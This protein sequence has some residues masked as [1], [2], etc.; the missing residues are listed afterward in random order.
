MAAHER[1]ENSYPELFPQDLGDRLERFTELAGLLGVELD[2]VMEWRGGEVPIGGEVWHI[3]R[4]ALSVSG[5]MDV[6]LP[7]A[8]GPD[9]GEE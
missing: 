3:M 7:E 2:R 5:G 9:E 8:T 6:M 4:L 1:T